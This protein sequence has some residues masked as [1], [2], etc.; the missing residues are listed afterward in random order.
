[1][2]ASI[3]LAARPFAADL[4]VNK[5]KPTWVIFD[6]FVHG[7]SQDMGNSIAYTGATVFLHSRT[8]PIRNLFP[9]VKSH[10]APYTNPR[11][12]SSLFESSSSECLR[13]CAVYSSQI[14]HTTFTSIRTMILFSHL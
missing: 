5:A 13:V 1:M 2:L 8:S 4:M 14:L 7:K 3:H 9:G 11:H 12:H 10:T 6:A